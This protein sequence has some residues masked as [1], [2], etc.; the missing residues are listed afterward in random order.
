MFCI[1]LCMVEFMLCIVEIFM[2]YDILRFEFVFDEFRTLCLVCVECRLRGRRYR[3]VYS[4][5]DG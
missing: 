1:G 2:F 5:K 4:E 3:G